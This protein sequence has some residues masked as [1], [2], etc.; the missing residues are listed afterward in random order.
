[1][2]MSGMRTRFMLEKLHR[3]IRTVDQTKFEA[4]YDI[5]KGQECRNG[6]ALAAK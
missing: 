1:M 2:A 6:R 4:R 5:Q 3:G